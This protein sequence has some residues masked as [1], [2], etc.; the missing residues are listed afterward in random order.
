MPLK[1][2]KDSKIRAHKQTIM[3]FDTDEDF[4]NFCVLP[5][6]TLEKSP[7]TGEPYEQWHFTKEYL[8][9]VAAGT[10]FKIKNEDSIIYKRG[11]VVGPGGIGIRVQ[12][13]DHWFEGDEE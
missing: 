10:R 7:I 6:T 9:A 2:T 5:Y 4:Q 8:D 1:L 3:Y 12:N 13:L 11:Q